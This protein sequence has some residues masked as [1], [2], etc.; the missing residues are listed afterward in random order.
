MVGQLQLPSIRHRRLWESV[1]IAQEAQE[2][3][4]SA[5]LTCWHTSISS[6]V[7]MSFHCPPYHSVAGRG[8]EE[9]EPRTSIFHVGHALAISLSS[10]S[11]LRTASNMAVHICRPKHGEGRQAQK[12][13]IDQTSSIKIKITIKIKISPCSNEPTPL[14]FA[15]IP[16]SPPLQLPAMPIEDS[17]TSTLHDQ[18]Q[19]HPQS[20]R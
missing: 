6:V 1:S 16:S 15:S 17:F 3:L 12:H 10:A 7:T 14:P 11:I 8:H 18:K 5:I 9:C 2:C 19:P 13:T 20:S 4:D